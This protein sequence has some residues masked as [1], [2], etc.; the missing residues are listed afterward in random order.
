[1][2]DLFNIKNANFTMTIGGNALTC[3]QSVNVSESAPVTEVE[4]AGA[5][6]VTYVTGL[7]RVTF[8][9]S[10][11]LADDDI[12]LM[13]NV[14]AND[15]GAMVLRPA[16]TTAGDIGITSTNAFITDIAFDF[17]V[18]G[19]SSYSGSGV[20]DDLTIAAISA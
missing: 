1:M 10:G 3:V 13:N 9:F 2:G 5:S 12:T 8:S 20:M 19:F 7:P 14:R 6:S 18:N 16:G 11:A 15:S 17:P 4:C